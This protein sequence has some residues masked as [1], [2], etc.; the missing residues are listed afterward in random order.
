MMMD[1]ITVTNTADAG[2]G[3]LRDALTQANATR[4][5]VIAF[6]IAGDDTTI[7]LQSSLPQIETPVT[8]D[9]TTQPGY[10]GAPVVEI[11]GQ[12]AGEHVAGL[13]IN[14][15]ECILRGLSIYGFG[16]S[17]VMLFEDAC[18][19]RVEG[20]CI[21][22][23]R[24][25]RDDIG[26]GYCG[27]IVY[28]ADCT[29]G[30]NTAQQRN[31]IS[32]NRLYGVMIAGPDATRNRLCGNHIGCDATGTRALANR[33]T[34]VLVF[35]AP[36]NLIGG[37]NKGEGNVIS[38]NAR[39]GINIDGS[40]TR[41]ENAPEHKHVVSIKGGAGTARNNIVAGNLVGTDATG[42][43]PLG[44]GLHGVIVFMAQYNTVGGDT[45]HARNV[46]SANAGNGV[47]ILGPNPETP[48]WREHVRS[49]EDGKVT[50]TV[51]KAAPGSAVKSNV[52][53]G[54]Y[55]GTDISGS[56][57]I[58]NAMSGV[59]ISH[60]HK[61]IIGRKTHGAGNVISGNGDNGVHVG[62]ETS[63]N[64]TVIG[65]IIDVNAANTEKCGNGGNGVY[66]RKSRRTIIGGPHKA[67]R[68][69][70]VGN[71][72][73]GILVHGRSLRHYIVQNEF[74]LPL[75]GSLRLKNGKRRPY[76]IKRNLA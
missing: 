7:R 46:I 4:N 42:T 22:T 10:D 28:A 29:I 65:N 59:R 18:K 5:A 61:N 48:D 69:I 53:T 51:D 24:H 39:H 19:S 75:Y 60:S 25:N 73:F 52:V 6:D 43:K 17:G 70:I 15:P 45:R 9:A 11:D 56:Y 76:R 40:A 54:N 8:I 33:R 27:L 34:G 26:N 47:F 23:N 20:N 44:N 49:T 31:V 66:I 58:G 16:G 30:G 72:K 1:A 63:I 13:F 21:G 32:G 37:T 12:E 38:G 3:S 62:G 35:N 71:E 68:N 14:A 55:I 67:E 41:C 50:K 57:A 64:N 36:R 2:P 74:S